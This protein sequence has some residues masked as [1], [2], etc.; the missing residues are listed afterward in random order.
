MKQ[1]NV[2]CGSGCFDKENVDKRLITTIK[3]RIVTLLTVSQRVLV[4]LVSIKKKYIN[5]FCQNMTHF[6]IRTYSPKKKVSEQYLQP[7][8]SVKF[9]YEANTDLT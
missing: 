7:M 1:R 8:C 4:P 9:W 3:R 5:F 6:I 2:W